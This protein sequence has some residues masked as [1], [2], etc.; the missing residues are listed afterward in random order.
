MEFTNPLNKMRLVAEKMSEHDYTERCNIDQKDEIALAQM[1]DGLGER[2]PGADQAAKA[3]A[4]A[5]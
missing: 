5:P 4:A 1:L 3:G 2:S